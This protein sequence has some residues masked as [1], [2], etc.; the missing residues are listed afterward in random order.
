LRAALDTGQAYTAAVA[1]LQG[2]DVPA[3]LSDHAATGLPTLANLQGSFPAAARAA[4]D[5][6]LRANPGETWTDR[7]GT[8]LRSQTGARSVTPREGNDPDAVLSR[9]EAA[10]ATGDLDTALQEISALPDEAKAAM[11]DW[12]NLAEQRRAAAAAIETLATTLGG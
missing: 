9:A 4:L 10:L 12:T 3:A 1:M 2:S 7:V 11:T 8:F 5:A 6:A